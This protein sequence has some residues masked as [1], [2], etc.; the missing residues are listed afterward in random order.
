MMFIVFFIVNK[1]G[2]KNGLLLVGFL[3]VFC[4]I[5]LGFVV[6][7]IGIFLMKL[8]YVLELFIMLIVIFKYFVVN[9]DIRLFFVLYLVGF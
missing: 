4:I 7:L 6:G 2:V 1:I 5:G 3:M 8:I 9:F